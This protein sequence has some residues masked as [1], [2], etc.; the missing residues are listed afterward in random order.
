MPLWNRYTLLTDMRLFTT[1]ISYN[2]RARYKQ[3]KGFGHFYGNYILYK[4]KLEHPA[5]KWGVQTQHS[6]HIICLHVHV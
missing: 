3:L 5:A 1:L 4:R 6:T 2:Q